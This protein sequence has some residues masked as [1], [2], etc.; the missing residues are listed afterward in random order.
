M[1]IISKIAIQVA[2]D[3]TLGGSTYSRRRIYWRQW[4]YPSISLNEELPE[5]YTSASLYYNIVY[6]PN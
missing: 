6:K 1:N 4:K 2:K 3:I 5:G